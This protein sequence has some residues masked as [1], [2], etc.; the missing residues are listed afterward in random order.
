MKK[1]YVTK[2]GLEKL[3]EELDHLKKVKRREVSS[4]I[5]KALEE[6]DISESGE[7]SEAKDE[8]AFTEGKIAELSDRIKNAVVIKKGRRGAGK[9]E[10]GS[11]VVVESDGQEAKYI[12]MGSSEA[13]PAEGKISNESPLGRAF[14]GHSAGEE[15]EVETPKGLTKFKIITIE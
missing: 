2:G 9:V 8:Q 7:Y 4:R 14:L 3:K 5:R 6:G 1:N 15:V 13:N 10:M 11:T 12:I